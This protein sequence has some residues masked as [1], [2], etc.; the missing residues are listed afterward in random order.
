MP[1]VELLTKLMRIEL[2]GQLM[3]VEEGNTPWRN[4]CY[5]MNDEFTL[6]IYLTFLYFKILLFRKCGRI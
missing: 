6:I 4:F 1:G 2:L 3:G 5:V